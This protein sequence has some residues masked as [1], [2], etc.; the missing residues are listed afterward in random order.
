MRTISMIRCRMQLLRPIAAVFAMTLAINCTCLAAPP[1]PAKLK[2]TL[3]KRGIGMGFKIKELDG[4]TV[5]GVLTA[6]H[7]DTFE[8]TAKGT[9]QAIVIPY[10]QVS[11]VHNQGSGTAGSTAAKIGGGVAIGAGVLVVLFFVVA[12]VALH[13]G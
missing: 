5:T 10:A 8:V 13:G 11:A 6:I 12:L 2:L 4:T 7:N 9:T 1:T 3:M